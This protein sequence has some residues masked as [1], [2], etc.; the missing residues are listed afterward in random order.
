MH[1]YDTESF[2]EACGTSLPE[3]FI[4]LKDFPGKCESCTDGVFSTERPPRFNTLEERVFKKAEDGTFLASFKIEYTIPDMYYDRRSGNGKPI[5][6]FRDLPPET[7]A[8]KF[9]RVSFDKRNYNFVSAS[10]YISIRANMAVGRGGDL[11]LFRGDAEDQARPRILLPLETEEYKSL[12]S[13]NG[14]AHAASWVIKNTLWR[15]N[16]DD[17]VED[18]SA[19]RLPVD[20]GYFVSP[21]TVE[22]ERVGVFTQVVD[23]RKV[24]S[25]PSL[26]NTYDELGYRFYGGSVVEDDSDT[27]GDVSPD[28]DC[29]G[30]RGIENLTGFVYKVGTG[31]PSNAR[32]GSVVKVCDATDRT[33]YSGTLPCRTSLG[34]E[35]S[36][37][38]SNVDLTFMVP[39][40]F[41][42]PMPK[43]WN[44]KE[45]GKVE[46]DGLHKG[47]RF[48]VIGPD[49]ID[50]RNRSIVSLDEFQNRK[51]DTDKSWRAGLFVRGEGDREDEANGGSSRRR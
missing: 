12:R 34:L 44:P 26:R 32:S 25:D 51:L 33:E 17:F 40:C 47:K 36:R 45:G 10:L 4:K 24:E 48:G 1:L 9:I 39:G 31:V 8:Q 30:L 5:V 19:P 23:S 49:S 20:M 6:D 2:R 35:F 11:I 27:D 21:P 43:W 42:L 15:F 29:V 37:E 46:I 22:G 13:K 38:V 50:V 28:E 16:G 3:N 14:E 18:R 7:I 41:E